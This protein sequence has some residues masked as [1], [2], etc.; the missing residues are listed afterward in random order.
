MHVETAALDAKIAGAAAM[1]AAKE[2][3]IDRAHVAAM[4][5]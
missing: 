5:A 3:Q 1:I 2:E 4:A